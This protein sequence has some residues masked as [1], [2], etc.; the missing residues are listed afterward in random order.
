[1]I[2]ILYDRLETAFTSNG[3]GRLTDC[4]SCKVIEERNGIYECEFQYPITGSHY[5][6][7][8]VGRIIGCTHDE[9]GDIQPF[10][11]YR[12]S[13]PIN[14]VVTYNARHISYRLNEITVKPFTTDSC[15]LALSKI[16]SES[17]T[18]N[19][20]TFWTDKTVSAS[21]TNPSPHKARAML[22]GEQNSILDVFGTGEYEFDQFDV[23]LYVNRGQD[24]N[25]SIRYGK[26]LTNFTNN[27]DTDQVYTHVVPFWL[28]T[29]ENETEEL[30]TLPEWYLSSG[31]TVDSGRAVCIPLDM[32]MDFE[33]KPTVSQLRT[34]AQSK[35]SASYGWLPNQTID[36]DF[37]QLWQTD[38][39]KEFA[40]LQRCRLCDTV[41]VFVPMYNMSLRAKII[42][43]EWNVLLDRYNSMTLGDKPT[44]YAHVI[45]KQFSS[46]VEGL[47]EGLKTVSVSVNGKS[48]IYYGTTSG[49]YSNVKTGD[50]LVDSTDGATYRWDGSQ[51]V[52]QTDYKTYAD[53]LVSQSHTTWQS[54]WEQAISDATDQI[55]GGDGGY[56]VTN[57]NANGQPIE[58]LVVDNLNLNQAQ[59][60]WRWNQGGFGHSSNGYNGTYTT[61]ITQDGKINASFITTGTLSANYIKAGTLSDVNNYTTF[62]LSTGVLTMTKGSINIGSGSF[63]VD[64][65]GNLTM[66]KG[67]ININS[68]AFKVTSAGVL[69]ATSAT[70]S[71]S[72]T[73]RDGTN[74]WIQMNAG[75]MQGG[76][77]SG[78]TTGYIAFNTQYTDT[79]RYGM[80]VAGYGVLALLCP[81][82]GVGSYVSK[83]SDS[84]VD[85]GRTKTITY[86][87]SISITCH[88]WQATN[89]PYVNS[90]W[91]IV[92]KW[93]SIDLLDHISWDVNTTSIRFTK[94]LMT[95]S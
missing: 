26:N 44:T 53:N 81:Y 21:Y 34:S 57:V 27:Y 30:V 75:Y 56:V 9:Y 63:V 58:L 15:A 78:T 40:P 92:G 11:I 42:K 31:H 50:Y 64:T 4:I 47:E 13:E 24:T 46:K 74:N 62:N 85:V 20:F 67:S 89:I 83:A 79:G 76:N 82:L 93:N 60:V 22:G 8:E 37:V 86:M 28:G 3:L 41:G 55:R 87:T 1:M 18:E 19:P 88:W 84:T 66:T 49:T 95:T 35:L 33:A 7:I 90:S 69:T 77:V 94:G 43:I 16:K 68:G 51:W 61:A 52:K 39:Y 54:E 80:R 29:N 32:S 73:S 65:S 70:L 14:G 2:P 17:V 91:D 72:I 48:T 38:E 12:K 25:I 23:K 6:D 45:E 59:N 5:D 36:I 71:G 10:D